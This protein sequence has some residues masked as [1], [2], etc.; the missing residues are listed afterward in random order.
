MSFDFELISLEKSFD[1][2]PERSIDE[3]VEKFKKFIQGK[4]FKW[5][6]EEK[7]ELETDKF[8][9]D[10][11]IKNTSSH[12]SDM[13]KYIINGN[14]NDYID[15]NYRII[16]FDESSNTFSGTYAKLASFKFGEGQVTFEN[17]KI[18]FWTLLK[19]TVEPRSP[20]IN[21]NLYFI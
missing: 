1:E 11:S 19:K 4:K 10:E 6:E 21:P 2:R 13:A 14:L 5:T 17:G 18:P 9:T 15:K 16:G 8:D 20:K 3:E 12:F 7:I